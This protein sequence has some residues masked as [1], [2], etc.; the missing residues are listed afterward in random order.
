M[1]CTLAKP[2]FYADNDSFVIEMPQYLPKLDD[3]EKYWVGYHTTREY[4]CPKSKY[5]NMLKLLCARFKL[6]LLYR[7]VLCMFLKT[8]TP[9]LFYNKTQHYADNELL[10]TMFSFRQKIEPHFAKRK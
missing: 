1:S 10:N 5:N 4:F 3:N 6:N 9:F 8:I 7:N 2:K